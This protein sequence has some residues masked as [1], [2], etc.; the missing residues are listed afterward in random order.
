MMKNKKA[1]IDLENFKTEVKKEFCPNLSQLL[2][3]AIVLPVSTAGWERSFSDMHRIK[4]WLRATMFQE[5]FLNLS[6]LNIEN[7]IF[8]TYCLK[9]K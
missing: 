3:A 7:E 1:G 2:Q 4:T 5:K 6:L 9:S 8:Q